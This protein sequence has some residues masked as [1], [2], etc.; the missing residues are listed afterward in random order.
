MK[1]FYSILIITLL[2]MSCKNIDQVSEDTVPN[3]APALHFPDDFLGKYNGTLDIKSPRGAQSLPMEFHL[4]PTDTTGRYTY[5]LVYD[6]QP[7]DY[8][9]VTLDK[10]KGLYEIDE[11]NGIILPSYLDQNTLHSFFEVQGNLLTTRMQFKQ[12]EMLFEIL[13]AATKNK[14]TTGGSSADIPEVAGYPISTFQK[15]RLVRSR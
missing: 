12:D 5:T 2:T 7:R 3:I 6:G 8:T 9:L 15:A 10:D 1:L 13:F 14:V 11:N 4:L